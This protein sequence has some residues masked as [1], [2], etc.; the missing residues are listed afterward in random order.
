MV[1]ILFASFSYFLIIHSTNTIFDV[2]K[3]LTV[4]FGKDSVD[5]DTDAFY[6]I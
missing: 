3:I 5:K 2:D 1:L 4:K 6:Q